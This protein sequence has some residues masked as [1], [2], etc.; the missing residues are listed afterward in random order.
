MAFKGYIDAQPIDPGAVTYG[1][2]RPDVCAPAIYPGRPNCPNVGW[3]YLADLSGLAN[4]NHTF[5]F[6]A[7]AANGQQ[8][9]VVNPFAVDNF[10]AATTTNGPTVNIDTPSSSAGTLSGVIPVAGWAIDPVSNIN[11]VEIY[12]D[13]ILY[14]YPTYGTVRSDVCAVFTT[15]PGCPDVGFSGSLDTTLLSDGT[16]TLQVL[17]YPGG[18]Q[19]YSATR[20]ITVGNQASTGVMINIDSPNAASPNLAGLAPILGWAVGHSAPIQSVTISVDGVLNGTATYGAL[21]AGCLFGASGRTELPQCRLD[22]Y[23]QH[24]PSDERLSLA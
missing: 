10:A 13:G 19:P 23:A 9:T 15:A 24:K 6:T 20:Q 16:H 11:L 21:P 3:R 7:I 22:L 14:S 5:S 2:P 1:A 12:V 17:A 4:G 8:Y 18:G